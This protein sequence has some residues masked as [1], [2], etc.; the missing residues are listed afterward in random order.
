M[1][2]SLNLSMVGDMG[3]TMQC[4]QESAGELHDVGRRKLSSVPGGEGKY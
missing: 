1:R 4:G 3:E 2:Y